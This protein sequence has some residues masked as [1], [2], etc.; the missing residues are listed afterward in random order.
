MGNQ[1]RLR[2]LKPAPNVVRRQPPTGKAPDPT[3]PDP[4]LKE[5]KKEDATDAL[6]GGLKTVA[7]EAVKNEKLKTFGL[8]LAKKYALPIWTGASDADKAALVAGGGLIV[9]TGLGAL[10]ADPVGRTHLSGI[11]F[12]APLSLVPYATLSG[13]QY[14]LPKSKLDPLLLHLSFKADDL[15]ALAKIKLG[16]QPPITASFDITLSVGPDG[17]V[18]TPSALAK[19]GVVPGVTIAGGYGLATDLPKLVSS[20]G[21]DPLLSSKSLPQAATPAPP[22]GAVIYVGVDLLQ[23]PF[24]PKAVRAALGGN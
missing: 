24:V 17:K 8:D 11:N 10:L 15:I 7:G 13:F 12:L 5:A 1:A 4:P 14:D 19:F 20:P 9:G 6:G 23:A 21:A 16:S 2:S 18:T 3:T 22:G